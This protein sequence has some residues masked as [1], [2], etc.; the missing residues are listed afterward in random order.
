MGGRLCA[1]LFKDNCEIEKSSRQRGLKSQSRDTD[2]E[3]DRIETIRKYRLRRQ[4][5]GQGWVRW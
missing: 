4:N 3:K 5:E 1:F 2:G